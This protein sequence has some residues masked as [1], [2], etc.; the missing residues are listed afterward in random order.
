[1]TVNLVDINNWVWRWC[2]TRAGR[3]LH[4]LSDIDEQLDTEFIG[5][6]G[7]GKSLCGISGRFFMPGIFSRLGAMRC[8]KCCKLAG[9]YR[10]YGA[11]YNVLNGEAKN[12]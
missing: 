11:P 9:I 7:Q 2:Q 1:M 3:I 10:G 8:K 4:R 5:R 12:A 6:S